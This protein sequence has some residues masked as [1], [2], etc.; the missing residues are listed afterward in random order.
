MLEGDCWVASL[1]PLRAIE[2]D[3]P[4]RKVVGHLETIDKIEIQAHRGAENEVVK[5]KVKTEEVSG[6][7]AFDVLGAN[8]PRRQ[9]GILLRPLGPIEEDVLARKVIG[10]L[11]FRPWRAIEGDVPGGKAA[12]HLAIE[13]DGLERKDIGQLEGDIPARK[14]IRQLVFRPL[15]AIQGDLSKRKAARQLV[16]FGH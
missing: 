14:A 15:R 8:E 13:G 1:R 7:P 10:Q 5:H 11:V 16:V 3:V 4:A 9:R 12:V 2:G 6:R